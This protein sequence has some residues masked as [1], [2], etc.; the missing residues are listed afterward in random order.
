[1]ATAAQTSNGKAMDSHVKDLEAQIASLKTDVS[2]L[3]ATLKD[4]TTTAGAEAKY[5]ASST[6]KKARAQGEKAYHDAQDATVAAYRNAENQVRENPAAAVGIA[7]GV[8]F[9]IG[10]FLARK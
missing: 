5:R 6:A 9:V 3:T 1:M 7:A 4:L 2:S 8:G 10:L